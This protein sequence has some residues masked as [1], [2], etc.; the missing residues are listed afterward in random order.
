MIDLT[1]NELMEYINIITDKNRRIDIS[2]NNKEMKE[3]LQEIYDMLVM[4]TH[5]LKEK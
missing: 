3:R 1:E 5:Q 4:I 2:K